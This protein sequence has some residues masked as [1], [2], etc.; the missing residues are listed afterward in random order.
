MYVEVISSHSNDILVLSNTAFTPYYPLYNRLRG[1]NA[2]LVGECQVLQRF[3]VSEQYLHFRATAAC[4]KI[5]H[6]DPTL[7]MIW[8]KYVNTLASEY[9]LA[10][11]YHRVTDSLWLLFFD[12][13]ATKVNI[14]SDW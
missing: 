4:L 2:A 1:V 10:V 12:V 8:T 9:P 11:A 3:T 6:C 7:C 14:L 13:L 5:N